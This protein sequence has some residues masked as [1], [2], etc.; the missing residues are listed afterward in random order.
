MGQIIQELRIEKGLTQPQLAKEID[1]SMS[2]VRSYENGYREPNSKAMAALERFFG[3]SGAYLR[4]ETDEMRAQY[5]WENTDSM[6]QIASDF[7]EQL[8]RLADLL[9]EC[10]EL[11][12]KMAFDILVEL[13]HILAAKRYTTE[14]RKAALLLLQKVFYT[15]TFFVD[16]CAAAS[17]EL[18]EDKE[19]LEKGCQDAADQMASALSLAMENITQGKLIIEA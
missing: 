8:S 3:V 12:Q 2:A 5:K 4:G 13:R 16:A 6:N 14:Q 11:E 1:V 17:I 15:S 18:P 10:S 9:S 7:P 19:R